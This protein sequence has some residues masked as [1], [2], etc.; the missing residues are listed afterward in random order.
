MP[1]WLFFYKKNSM[2][3]WSNKLPELIGITSI[4]LLQQKFLDNWFRIFIMDL[5]FLLNKGFRPKK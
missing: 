1:F 2:R 3:T 4:Q 5:K